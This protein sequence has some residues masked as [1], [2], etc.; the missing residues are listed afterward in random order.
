MLPMKNKSSTLDQV[1]FTKVGNAVIIAIQREGGLCMEAS[2]PLPE[3]TSPP[4][5]ETSAHQIE[6]CENGAKGNDCERVGL[7]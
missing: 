6:T 5:S 3:R 1:Y 7:Q 4:Q 2:L